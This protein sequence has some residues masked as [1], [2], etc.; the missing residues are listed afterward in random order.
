MLTEEALCEDDGLLTPKVGRWAEE[1]HRR[2]A[3]YVSMFATSMKDKWDCRVYIGL[4]AGAGKGRMAGSGRI[5][6]GSPLLALNIKY[7][8]D[9]YV[10]CER[11][12]EYV[13][14]LEQRVG[15][16]FPHVDC[17]CIQG[18]C[19]VAVDDIVGTVPRFTKDY[20]GL[21]FCL[22]DPYGA[23]SLAFTTLEHLASRLYLDFLVLIPTCMD[24]R[25]NESY[26]S[27]KEN[28]ILD[29]YLGT[30]TWRDEWVDPARPTSDFGIFIAERFC[31]KMKG[32]GFLYE[33]SADM[34][35]IRTYG[36]RGLE[37]YHLAFFSKH[38]LGL[39]SWRRTKKGTRGQLDLF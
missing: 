29:R 20:R 13:Q 39:R 2:I 26:N 22:V 31:E 17:E 3:Y 9:H 27:S 23:S 6:P 16:Y 7:P 12:P 19:N 33:S 34:D 18:D 28:P 32:I 4:F 8:F 5:V 37:L 24:I 10:F 38:D 21:T 14:A 15:D 11:E 36:E 35:L 30:T 25:R 1:K